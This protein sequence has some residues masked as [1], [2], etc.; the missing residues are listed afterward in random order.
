M[1]P[2]IV[3]SYDYKTKTATVVVSDSQPY[4]IKDVPVWNI[5]TGEGIFNVPLLEGTAGMLMYC[6]VDAYDFFWNGE[7]ELNTVRVGAEATPVFLPGWQSFI[8][9]YDVLED[10]ILLG[11]NNSRIKIQPDMLT[12]ESGAGSVVIEPDQ[13]TMRI[14]DATQLQIKDN[15]KF[16]VTNASGDFV[17]ECVDIIDQ[18]FSSLTTPGIFEYVNTAGVVTSCTVNTGVVSALKTIIDPKLEKIKSFKA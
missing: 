12:A 3:K 7:I 4:E 8:Q 5:Y 13:V 17:T 10:G 16:T 1:I 14:G 9:D 15:G 11:W 6:S 18:I 2:S